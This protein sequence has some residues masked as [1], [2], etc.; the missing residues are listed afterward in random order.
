MKMFRKNA[1]D[2]IISKKMFE[3]MFLDKRKTIFLELNN[4]ILDEIKDTNEFNKFHQ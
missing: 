2:A 3:L 4:Y 1:Y